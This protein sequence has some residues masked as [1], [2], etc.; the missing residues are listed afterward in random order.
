MATVPRIELQRELGHA[1]LTKCSSRGV[2][3]RAYR[4]PVEQWTSV[5]RNG[6]CFIPA[7]N[8]ANVLRVSNVCVRPP[9]PVSSLCRCTVLHVIAREVNLPRRY[10]SVFVVG[11]WTFTIK[12]VLFSWLVLLWVT[13]TVVSFIMRVAKGERAGDGGVCVQIQSGWFRLVLLFYEYLRLCW[14]CRD[15]D[16]LESKWNI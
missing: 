3:E 9:S 4:Q 7:S 12:I 6:E 10:L 15:L 13:A 8:Y 16:G 14:L 11:H 5:S 2:D 1:Y